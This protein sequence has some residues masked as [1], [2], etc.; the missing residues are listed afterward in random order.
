MQDI[1]TIRQELKSEFVNSEKSK[2]LVVDDEQDILDFIKYNLEK[3]SFEVCTCNESLEVTKFAEK[4]QPDLIILDIM[5]PDLDGVEL[6]KQLRSMKAF[7]NTLIA[8]L[9]ARGEDFSEIAALEAGGDDYIVKPIRPR[10]FISRVRALLRRSRNSIEPTEAKN[11]IEVADLV[12]NKEKYILTKAGEEL[13]LAKKEFEILW[14]L[15]SRPGKVFSRQEIFRN[16]WDSDVIVG[17]RTIDVHIRKLREKIGKHYIKTIKGI[18]Y[19]FD[20]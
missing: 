10:T 6:C 4:I 16:I 11:I 18:G 20:A 2:I 17:Q 14:L 8:F 1:R 3:E 7:E 5:M 12:I 15:L 19:K 13:S 9:T